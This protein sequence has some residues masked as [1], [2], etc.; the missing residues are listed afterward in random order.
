VQVK[1][2]PHCLGERELSLACQRGRNHR[3]LLTL[4]FLLTE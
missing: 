4:S 3:N 2:I 1:R